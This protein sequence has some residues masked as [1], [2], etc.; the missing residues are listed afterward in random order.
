MQGPENTRL[1][2]VNST[3]SQANKLL[4]AFVDALSVNPMIP[5]YGRQ[6]GPGRGRA[7]TPFNLAYMLRS[8]YTRAGFHCCIDGVLDGEGGGHGNR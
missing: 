5:Q 1:W 8:M 7:Y 4:Q 2:C 6:H 3:Y